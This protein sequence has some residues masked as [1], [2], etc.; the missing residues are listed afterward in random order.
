MFVSLQI[1][2]CNS[3]AHFAIR[4]NMATSADV[5]MSFLGDLS[6]IVRQKADEV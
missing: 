1:M 4:P 6:A 5:V 3:Y 2:G